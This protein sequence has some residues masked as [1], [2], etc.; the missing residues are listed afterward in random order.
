MHIAR[1]YTSMHTERFEKNKNKML[2]IKDRFNTNSYSPSK[3]MRL[4]PAT[5]SKFHPLKKY[6]VSF[7][8]LSKIFR[9]LYLFLLQQ[10][11]LNFILYIN[12]VTRLYFLHSFF[13]I[14]HAQKNIICIS[15]IK[16][17]CIL[18]F[19]FT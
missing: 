6:F 3:V 12:S 5:S 18:I 9:P 1:R 4:S 8:T 16:I 17:R 13:R 15:R 7:T 19:F 14:G 2:H 10:R 11:P